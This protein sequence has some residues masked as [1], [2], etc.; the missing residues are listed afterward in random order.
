MHFRR[1]DAQQGKQKVGGEADAAWC[2]IGF[3][4]EFKQTEMHLCSS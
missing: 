2:R 3:P 1:I 4:E